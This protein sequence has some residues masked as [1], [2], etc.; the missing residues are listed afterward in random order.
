MANFANSMASF[1]FCSSVLN[2]GWYNS[3]SLD[4]ISSFIVLCCMAYDARAT[5]IP[6]SLLILCESLSSSLSVD[7]GKIILFSIDEVV[8]VDCCDKEDDLN[9]DLA[10]PSDNFISGD[11][12]KISSPSAYDFVANSPYCLVEWL[13]L[14]ELDRRMSMDD[15]KQCDC[16]RINVF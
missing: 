4:F 1:S 14:A 10:S 2:S 7:C 11:S 6:Q 16:N 13:S 8:A 9:R 5:S 15:N 12:S 3:I